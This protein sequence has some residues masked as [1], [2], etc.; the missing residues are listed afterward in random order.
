MFLRR[1]EHLRE[2]LEVL[3]SSEMSSR[4]MSVA[5]LLARLRLRELQASERLEELEGSASPERRMTRL[6]GNLDIEEKAA[7]AEV[8]NQWS[9]E[10]VRER[11][12]RKSEVAQHSAES[13]QGSLRT[14]AEPLRSIVEEESETPPQSEVSRAYERLPSGELRYLKERTM[15]QGV[16]SEVEIQVWI[17]ATKQSEGVNPDLPDAKKI[18]ASRY[19]MCAVLDCADEM[20][21]D[22]ALVNPDKC[23]PVPSDVASWTW[24]VRPRKSGSFK[25]DVVVTSQ[26]RL[27]G[28]GPK[29][30]PEVKD[31]IE[32]HVKVNRW[33]QTSEFLKKHWMW[34]LGGFGLLLL[35]TWKLWLEHWLENRREG[36]QQSEDHATQNSPESHEEAEQ[37]EPNPRGASLQPDKPLTKPSSEDDTSGT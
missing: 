32:I 4:E 10:G 2:R 31:H 20:A 33:Y 5:E 19:E 13:Q 17:G 23:Q 25:L 28:Q 29:R 15:K 34:F 1:E 3:M 6:F 22:I 14:P 21:F 18:K 26:I 7:L 24:N 11:L 9:G 30:Q 16:F 8:V 36:R 37:T 35:A 12:E 27:E